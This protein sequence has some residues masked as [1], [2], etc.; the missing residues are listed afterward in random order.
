M[1]VCPALKAIQLLAIY[2]ASVSSANHQQHNGVQV[3]LVEQGNHQGRDFQCKSSIIRPG[4]HKLFS[5][6]NSKDSVFSLRVKLSQSLVKEAHSGT[7]LKIQI[8]DKYKRY[9]SSHQI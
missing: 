9:W 5:I 6:P 7:Y 3:D 1:N 8:G 4:R 2:L